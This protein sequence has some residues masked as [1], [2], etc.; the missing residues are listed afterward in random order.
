MKNVW[1]WFG[2]AAA[3]LTVPAF[4]ADGWFV[5]SPKERAVVERVGSVNR[6]VSSG[7]HFCLP[8]PFERVKRYPAGLVISDGIKQKFRTKDSQN[9]TLEFGIHYRLTAADKDDSLKEIHINFTNQKGMDGK[10]ISNAGYDAAVRRMAVAAAGGVISQMSILDAAD[11][12]KLGADIKKKLSEDL[13]A[14]KY[15]F[16]IELAVVASTDLDTAAEDY[17]N[18]IANERQKL[19]IIEQ[20]GANAEKEKEVAEKEGIAK[21]AGTIS[22]LQAEVEGVKQVSDKYALSFSDAM[23]VYKTVQSYAVISGQDKVDM[24]AIG[25]PTLPLSLTAPKPPL[26]APAK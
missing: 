11:Y 26:A 20:R 7:F 2:L 25:T 23:D 22:R 17:A 4:L 24:L 9:F 8:A 21:A 1:T 3:T 16:D 13:T 5:V 12:G 10:E 6:V 18:R 19:A 14:A 15:P